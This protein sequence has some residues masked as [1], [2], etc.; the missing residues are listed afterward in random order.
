MEVGDCTVWAKPLHTLIVAAVVACSANGT[1]VP[2]EVATK[3]GPGNYGR[4]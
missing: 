2:R 3:E 1:A 4:K